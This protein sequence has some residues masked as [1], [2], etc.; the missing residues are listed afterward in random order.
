MTS[1]I[2]INAANF[3]DAGL[4]GLTKLAEQMEQ[5]DLTELVRGNEQVFLARYSPLARQRSMTLDLS[6]VKRIDAA[7]IAAL[8]ALHACAHEAGHCFSV[9]NPTPHVAEILALVGLERLLVSH[10]TN[11]NS[12]YDSC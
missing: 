5:T 10:N 4:Y 6:P 3:P 12:H 7:G 9:V 2:P 8:I 11:I 1:T